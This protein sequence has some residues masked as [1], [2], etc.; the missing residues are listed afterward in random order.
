MVLRGKVLETLSLSWG[1][2]PCLLQCSSWHPLRKDQSRLG[3][4]SFFTCEFWALTELGHN[5][6]LRSGISGLQ[7][8]GGGEKQPRPPA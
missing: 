4:W 1:P 3:S 6:Q 5:L 8:A 2:G 7:K